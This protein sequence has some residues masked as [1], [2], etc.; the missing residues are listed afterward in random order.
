MPTVA[1]R[2]EPEFPDQSRPALPFRPLLLRERPLCSGKL[3]RMQGSN[4]LR[5][6][7]AR[8]RGWVQWTGVA[9]PSRPAARQAM[10]PCLPLRLAAPRRR[11]PAQIGALRARG[12][13]RC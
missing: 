9:I 1:F 7:L 13:F 2:F 3:E 12:G 11:P 10:S 5:Q 6:Q 4:P 8:R